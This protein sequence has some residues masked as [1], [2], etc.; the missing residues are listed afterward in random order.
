[1]EIFGGSC[2]GMN[3]SRA[4]LVCLLR[5][6]VCLGRLVSQGGQRTVW[7]KSEGCMGYYWLISTTFVGEPSPYKLGRRVVQ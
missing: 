7:G 4:E 5:V 3:G 1:M 2:G 6:G